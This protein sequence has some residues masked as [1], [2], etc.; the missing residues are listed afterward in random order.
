MQERASQTAPSPRQQ[1]SDSVAPHTPPPSPPSRPSTRIGDILVE[2]GFLTRQELKGALLAA[3]R[4]PQARL[5]ELLIEMGYASYKM[6]AIALA[7]QYGRPFASLS[8]QR[9][10]PSLR[11]LLHRDEALRWQLLPLALENNVLTVAIVDPARTEGLETLER[12]S[13]AVVRTVISTPQDIQHCVVALFYPDADPEPSALDRPSDGS[14]Y[15][16]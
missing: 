9:V 7:M 3:K 13:G 5:G 16:G 2:Q 12:R 8:G 1:A 10:D 14:G 11:E 6:I 4:Q 15:Q